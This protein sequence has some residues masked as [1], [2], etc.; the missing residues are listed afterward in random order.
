MSVC[1]IQIAKR[2]CFCW[3]FCLA[4]TSTRAQH[5][6]PN[7]AFG[8]VHDSQDDWQVYD[9]RFK[10]YVPYVEERHSGYASYSLFF[11]FE[12]YKNYQ[13]LYQSPKEVYLFIDGALQKR[14]P[15]NAWMSIDVDS[16][17][18]TY[19]KSQLFLTF[20]AK[21]LRVKDLRVIV[22]NRLTANNIEIV[23]PEEGLQF[24][25]RRMSP[26]QHFLILGSIFLLGMYAFLYNYQRRAF[27]RFF[28]WR[29]LLSI[30]IRDDS[31]LVN[32]PFDITNLFFVFNLSLTIGFLVL[33]LQN[34]AG[35]QVNGDLLTQPQTSFSLWVQYFRV[36][37]LL[38]A[39][40]MVKYLVLSL[41]S[42]LYRLRRVSNIHFFK[43]IQ[44]SNFFFLGLVIVALLL[45]AL[46]PYGWNILGRQLVY[47]VG[48]F[49][50]L[51]MVLLY[52]TINKMAS[53][54]NLYLISY[55]CIVEFIP[56]IIGVRF[57]IY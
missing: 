52:F 46:R 55:L 40:F 12:N 37:L 29:D 34:N 22:G 33:L 23:L 43:I 24:L 8:L 28:S 50:L 14:L 26:F 19:Q 17:Q 6:G 2:V 44:A 32:K 20:Y 39:A 51:R 10:A 54:K 56:L 11:D 31:F 53:L 7:N 45:V 36:S 41:M 13:L 4:W 15:A 38:F 21:D 47:F 25:P 30:D 9:E 16:L 57:S 48:G 3:C 1:P 5:V 18:R 49:F 27:L 35:F 42:A